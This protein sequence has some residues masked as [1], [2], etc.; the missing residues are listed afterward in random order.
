[1][2]LPL[3]VVIA[4][5]HMCKGLA[6]VASWAGFLPLALQDPSGADT[7]LRLSEKTLSQPA[8]LLPMS[9]V[10]AMAVVLVWTGACFALREARLSNPEAHR[11]YRPAVVAL[12]TCLA[13]LVFGWGLGA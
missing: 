13:F 10:S 6:K 2:A 4:A 7:A 8:A 5:G 1:M 3:A 9:V 11:A 12:A